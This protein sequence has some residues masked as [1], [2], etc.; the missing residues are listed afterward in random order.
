MLK[1][2]KAS[3]AI[4]LI[5][6]P[7]MAILLWLLAFGHCFHIDSQY[8]GFVYS[9]LVKYFRLYPQKYVAALCTILFILQAFHLNYI[10][11]RH[12]VLF[13]NTWLPSII[14]VMVAAAFTP[15]LSLHPLLLVQS[16]FIFILE[17]IF[18][19]YKNPET[20]AL[21]FDTGMLIGIATLI[22]L[23]SIFIF[24]CFFVGLFILKPFHWRDSLISLLGFCT[25]FFMFYGIL[26]LM[27]IPLPPLLENGSS[28]MVFRIPKEASVDSTLWIT[29]GILV[30]LVILSLSKL[31]ANFYKN[32]IRTRNM[33][34]MVFVFLLT[35]ILSSLFAGSLSFIRYYFVCAPVSVII[36][37]YFVA[38]KKVILP[39]I[40]FLSLLGSV[41]YNITR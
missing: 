13:A 9:H 2:L 25:P 22:Y 31:S 37:Y 39:E 38:T 18:R 27:R 26:F 29:I 11:N 17:K 1:L 34:Q 40:L 35:T 19:L 10:L 21:D 7:L 32:V 16:I 12:E 8:Q 33:Q 28:Q 6:M 36:S 24:L 4:P 20:K 14:Y 23:N 15:F 30:F 3:P 41:I 5:F